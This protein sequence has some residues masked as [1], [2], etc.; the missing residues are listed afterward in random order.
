MSV[1]VWWAGVFA[2]VP[3]KANFF[4][5]LLALVVSSLKMSVRR[6]G[7]SFYGALM[8]ADFFLSLS[9]LLVPS[10][11]MSASVRWAGVLRRHP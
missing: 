1:A 7:R 4:F 11:T 9:A 5:L 2:G 3:A 6:G 10:L 8:K